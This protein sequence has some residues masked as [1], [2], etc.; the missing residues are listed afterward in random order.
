[1]LR[2]PAPRTVCTPAGAGGG[3]APAT[4]ASD[5][6]YFV[7]RPQRLRAPV[8][9][10]VLRSPFFAGAQFAGACPPP[11][12]SCAFGSPPIFGQ[13]CFRLLG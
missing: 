4:G 7:L 3:H 13:R 11:A 12:P 9:L 6:L 8:F 2:R 1:M 5:G 10:Y